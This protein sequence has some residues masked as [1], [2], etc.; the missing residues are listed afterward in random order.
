[1]ASIKIEIEPSEITI[2]LPKAIEGMAI[3]VINNSHRLVVIKED[4]KET[5]VYNGV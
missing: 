2:T 1:M 3:D 5:H 4:S